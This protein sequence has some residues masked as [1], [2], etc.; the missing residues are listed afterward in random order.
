MMYTKQELDVVGTYDANTIRDEDLL[1]FAK[2]MYKE[3]FLTASVKYDPDTDSNVMEYRV[4]VVRTYRDKEGDKHNSS[5]NTDLNTS[6]NLSSEKKESEHRNFF[7][8]IFN[9]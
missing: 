6:D 2:Y 5:D 7:K 4:T 3:G 1:C 9:L 8:R